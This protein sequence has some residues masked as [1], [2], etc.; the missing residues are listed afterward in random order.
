[1]SHCTG[2]KSRQIMQDYQGFANITILLQ[3]VRQK[4]DSRRW[5]CNQRPYRTY[6]MHL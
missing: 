5:L 6:F 3:S 1:M 2:S 4:L